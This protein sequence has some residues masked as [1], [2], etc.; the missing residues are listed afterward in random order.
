MFDD[1]ENEH[2]CAKSLGKA[3]W[4]TTKQNITV[5]SGVLQWCVCVDVCSWK[6]GERENI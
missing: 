2:G 5:N 6:M 4:H 3:E 1:L